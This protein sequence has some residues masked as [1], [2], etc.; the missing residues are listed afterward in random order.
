MLVSMKK[1][2]L[3]TEDVMCHN[4]LVA[5]FW[6]EDGLSKVSEWVFTDTLSLPA[7]YWIIHVRGFKSGSRVCVFIYTQVTL[8]L[9]GEAD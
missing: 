5:V 3:N 4:G 9:C 7:L 1:A 6:D 8:P 2:V